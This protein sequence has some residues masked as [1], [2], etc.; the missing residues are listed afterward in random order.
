MYLAVGRRTSPEVWESIEQ[1]LAYASRARSLNLIGQLQSLSQRDSTVA[2]YIG[3]ARVI[4]EDLSLVSR[5]VGLD[6][7]NLY[8]FRSLRSE[9]QNLTA[10]LSVH[11]QPVTLGELA[12]FLGAQE[13]IRGSVTGSSLPSVADK[14]A[15]VVTVVKLKAVAALSTFEEYT[16]NDTLRVGDGKD[17]NTK[18]VLLQDNSSGGLYRLPIANSSPSAFLS[19]RMSPSMWHDRLGH[20]H[21]RVL[22]RILQSCSSHGAT[23]VAPSSDTAASPSPLHT[24]NEPA[25]LLEHEPHEPSAQPAK[26]PC[27]QPRDKSVK[28]TVRTHEMST[29]SRFQAPPSA[30]TV[31]VCPSD[32]TCY[33]QAVKY[34]ECREAMDQEFN[35]LLHNQTWH[36]VPS[37]ACMNSIGCKWVFHTKRKAD[38]S[39]ERHKAQL[40][41]KGFNQ[42]PGQDS[43]ILS[44][45]WSCLLLS[46]YVDDILMMGSDQDLV[47]QLAS[48]LS[49]AFK[50]RDLGEPGFFL[51]IETVKCNDGILLSQK[52]YM[53]DILKCAGLAECKELSTPIS[54]S[55]PVIIDTGL[56][57]DP[58][59]H[60]SLA[61][62]VQ[63]LTITRP[64][65]SFV[66]NQLCQH[67]HALTVSHWEQ[68]K[69]VLRYVKGIISF[70]LRVRKSSSREIH[71]FS[72]SN[73]AGCPED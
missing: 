2:D 20:P 14:L 61:S 64:D 3:R 30:L 8:V 19:A 47:T 26:R 6:E 70:S 36:L 66:V 73:C 71:A 48:K 29:R 5:S 60:K 39:I 35:A 51:G 63:Y 45:Q 11:G 59:Q 16:G 10:S 37:Q 1:S 27:G 24:A 34:P 38:G 62:A 55:K 56:Y 44:V 68:L 58:T 21:H 9:F 22:L 50:I 32:S 41:A 13:F 18:E 52:R 17:T 67:M 7:M 72:D 31:Q 15:E 69:R 49:T 28:S 33:T 40:V 4:M 54:T 46:V 42:V 12:D 43:L 23:D 65:L 57:D 53:N 25:N